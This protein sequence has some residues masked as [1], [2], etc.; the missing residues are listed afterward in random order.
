MGE[1]RRLLERGCYGSLSL[2]GECCSSLLSERRSMLVDVPETLVIRSPIPLVA[3]RM[4]GIA[5]RTRA[6]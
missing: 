5:V 1:E 6:I 3:D 4:R 2:R